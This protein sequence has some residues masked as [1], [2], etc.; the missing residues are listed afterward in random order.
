[1]IH[2][3]DVELFGSAGQRIRQSLPCEPSKPPRLKENLAP[4]HGTL[5]KRNRVTGVRWQA[6][7]RL[8]LDFWGRWT[9]LPPYRN[10]DIPAYW[11]EE[12]ARFGKT[13]ACFDGLRVL[14]VGCGPFGLIHFIDHARERVRIDPLLAQY[15]QKLPLEGRQLSLSAMGESL[16]L[17]ARS[18]DLAVCYNALDHM[19]DPD[20]ALDELARVL[21]PG[22]TA[23]LMIHTFPAWLRPLFPVDRM[24][25]HHFSAAAFQS[26]VRRRFQIERFETV[27]RHFELPLGTGLSPSFWKYRVGN[28]VVSSTYVSATAAE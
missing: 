21:R 25:P 14:D 26:M 16:P 24:H 17:A 12:V 4:G 15:R 20:A 5:K 1:M 7:Q 27:R 8:E 18:V 23:L 11:R 10:L 6:S 28:L 9:T 22:G 19:L 13:W 2:N 3:G